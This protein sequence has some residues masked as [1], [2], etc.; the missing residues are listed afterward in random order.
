YAVNKV[1]LIVESSVAI[2]VKANSKSIICIYENL[3][4]F[5]PSNAIQNMRWLVLF[6]IH[7]SKKPIYYLIPVV[8]YAVNKVKLIVE[9]SVAINVTWEPNG[10]KSIS[11]IMYRVLYKRDDK[12]QW[13]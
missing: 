7:L 9:S 5:L 12:H 8:P 4:H 1:K 13:Q 6:F 10:D 2:N 11:P 3:K